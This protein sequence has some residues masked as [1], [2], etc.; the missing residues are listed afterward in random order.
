MHSN[1]ITQQFTGFKMKITRRQLRQLI[2]NEVRIKPGGEL[3]PEYLEK[4]TSMVDTDDEAFIT[5]ADELAPMLGYEGD[6]F[7]QDIR[8][9]KYVSIMDAVGEFAHYLT[10]KHMKMLMNIKDKELHYA[11]YSWAGFGFKFKGPTAGSTMAIKPDDFYEMQYRIAAKKRDIDDNDIAEHEGMDSGVEAAHKL[12]QAIMS[13]SKQTLVHMY[14][15][16]DAGIGE[17][18]KPRVFDKYGNE[19]IDFYYPEYEALHKAG[20]LVITK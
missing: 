19:A 15:L 11:L 17:I 13:L 2:I 5:Q 7:A 8:A 18:R 3:S 6:S 14:T 4:L 9:Y 1:F 20:K 10:D 16:E 12:A